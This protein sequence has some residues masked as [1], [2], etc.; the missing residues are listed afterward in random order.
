MNLLFIIDEFTD[1]SSAAIVRQ[2]AGIIMDV[3]HNPYQTR[4]SCEWVGGEA[5]RQ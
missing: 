3:F 2:Q 1:I 5:T 4:P